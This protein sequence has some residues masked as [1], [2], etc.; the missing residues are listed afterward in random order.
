M[1]Q[2]PHISHDIKIM[3]GM[4]CMRGTRVTVGAMLTQL[5]EGRS[6]DEIAGDYPYFAREDIVQALQ[7]VAW[8]VQ[9]LDA[10]IVIA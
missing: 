6:I 10:G 4:A 8:T 3:G 7:Y 5:G 1:E 2:F 9:A